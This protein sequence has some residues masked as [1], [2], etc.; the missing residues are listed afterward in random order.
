MLNPASECSIKHS[1][2]PCLASMEGFGFWSNEMPLILGRLFW[3]SYFCLF[4]PLLCVYVM[5]LR[6]RELCLEDQTVEDE[7]FTVWMSQSTCNLL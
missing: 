4:A 2:V 6:F 3:R 1:V 7:V 5:M